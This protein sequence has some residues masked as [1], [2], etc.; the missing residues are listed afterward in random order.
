MFN[1]NSTTETLAQ[2]ANQQKGCGGPFGK[3]FGGKSGPFN[4]K[5]PWMKGFGAGNR[6]SANIQDTDEAFIITLYAAGLNKSDFKVAASDDILSISYSPTA[7]A[8]GVGKNYI[9][10]EYE[11][12]SFNRSFQL[13][14]KVL[15]DNINATYVDGVLKV[16]LIK[17]PETNRPATQINVD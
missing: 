6:K 4:G 16:T 8:E 17:N 11:P 10:K 7:T 5:A 3:K 1:R 12:S 13:N 2:D 14:G 15:T 9:H